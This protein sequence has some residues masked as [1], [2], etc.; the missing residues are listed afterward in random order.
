MNPRGKRIVLTCNTSWGVYNFRRGIIRRL[1]GL[2]ADV[3]VLAPPDDYSEALAAEVDEIRPIFIDSK[4]TNPFTDYRTVRNYKTS[5]RSLRPDLLI[6]YTI[7]PIIYASGPARSLRIP[8]LNVVTGLGSPFLQKV[9]LK[10]VVRFLYRRALRGN[11]PVFFL[12]AEDRAYFMKHQMVEEGRDRL[13]PGEG[14]DL[15]RFKETEFPE[16]V[17]RNLRIVY[18]GRFLAD[19]GLRELVE[20]FRRCVAGGIPVELDLVGFS[21]TTNPSAVPPGEISSWNSIDGIT[22]HPPTDD[23]NPYLRRAHLL[24]LPSYRE[25]LPRSILEAFSV[26]RPVLASDVAGCRDLVRP[27]QT[28][29][30]CPARD[31]GALEQGIRDI[32]GL[33]T[34]E[35]AE[36][37]RRGRRLVE[38][39]YGD[40]A[41]WARYA[42][43]L[44]EFPGD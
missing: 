33:N 38:E 6:A 31:A 14:V 43:A 17:G 32:V 25:G 28:G 10:R 27:G 8:V 34:R 29:W 23:V 11:A 30:L 7:K 12:N 1:R 37:G 9:A 40:D 16:R 19:K 36:T 21:E 22:V 18:C 3:R 4:G 41:V 2:G 5:L 35:I 42:E 26:G 39:I 44:A 20:A 15:V 13:I 24:V